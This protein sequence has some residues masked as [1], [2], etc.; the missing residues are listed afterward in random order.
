MQYRLVKFRGKYA[1]AWVVGGS[2]VRRSLRTDNR[3]IAERRFKAAVAEMG[4]P[5]SKIVSEMWKACQKDKISQNKPIGHNMAFHWKAIGPYFG[6][7][8]CESITKEDCRAYAELRRSQGRAESTIATELKHLRLTLNWAAKSKHIDKAPFI[9][10]PAESPARDRYLTKAEMR[11]FIDNVKSNHIRIAAE[12]LLAT[13]GRVGAVL[14]LTWD[15]V[16]FERGKIRLKTTE[17]GK[18]RA[19]VP[20]T[21]RARRVLEEAYSERLAGCPYVVHYGGKPVK[22]IRKGIANAAKDAGLEGVTPHVFRHTAA[23]WMAEDDHSMEEI[24]QFLGHRDIS[25]T[26]SVYARFSSEH[27]KKTAKSLD[28]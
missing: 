24:A 5:P 10:V 9:E 11:K 20:M 13:A 23:V 28:F 4:K 26:R 12:L 15:R 6:N 16:D 17:K 1:V 22:S 19:V 21:D 7:M 3:E 27:L 14:E 2:T 25:V 18:G 8:D